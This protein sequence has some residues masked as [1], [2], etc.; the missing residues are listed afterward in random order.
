MTL[1]RTGFCRAVVALSVLCSE[2]PALHAQQAEDSPQADDNA[3]PAPR[4]SKDKEQRAA[5][6]TAKE[7][8]EDVETARSHFKL[9][10][11]SYRDG[12]LTTALIE[13]KRAYA[14]AP[15]YRLLY[16]LGQVSRELRDYPAAERYFRDYLTQGSGEIE[17]ERRQ[18]VET[19]IAKA[20]AR[21]ASLVITVN[22]PNAEVFVDDVLVGR[23][24][25]GDVV[26][27]SAGQ[28]RI[29]AALPGRQ[30]ATEVVDAA[31]G[32]TLVVKLELQTMT[33]QVVTREVVRSVHVQA[34]SGP[35]TAAIVLG[36]GTA[37]LGVGAGVM[38]FLA[39][40]QSDDYQAAL[41]RK[42]SE[43]ELSSL[44]SGAKTKAL[45][46]DILLGATL[47]CG[48]TTL[49]VGLTSGGGSG[50]SERPP[51]AKGPVAWGVGPGS[52]QVNA[53]F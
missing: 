34:D 7:S 6:A 12:D 27:V 45:V 33:P 51:A 21:I 23:A 24:P 25:L 37:A 38:A 50:T 42:T 39:K 43:A 47:A 2:V 30:R 29:S 49:V 40:S 28:R 19:E 8:A 22:E 10:V 20:N 18:E 53:R 48:V 35:P 9:G 11:D 1:I 16:N 52:V 46:T 3:P 15:N 5:S 13:F 31:G 36:A 44:S 4:A 32:E 17:P 26:R 41:Q 14:A